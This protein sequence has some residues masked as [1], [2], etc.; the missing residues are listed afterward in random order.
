[1]SQISLDEFV[2]QATTKLNIIKADSEKFLRE[3]PDDE[4]DTAL[5]E[6]R[7]LHMGRLEIIEKCLAIVEEGRSINGSFYVIK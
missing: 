5:C 6:D 3:N 4:A 7:A 2:Q 1:M